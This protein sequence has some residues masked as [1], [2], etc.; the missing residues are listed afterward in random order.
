MPG[1]LLHC[2][3]VLDDPTVYV[4]DHEGT[5]VS[6]PPQTIAIAGPT[7]LYLL[8]APIFRDADDDAGFYAAALGSSS[9]WPGAVVYKSADQFAWT[10]LL[11]ITSPATVGSATT[12]L[13]DHGPY[14]WDEANTVTIRLV[15]GSLASDSELNVLN[16]ANAG[17][18]ANEVL[19]WR[20]ATL[21]GDGTYTLSGLLRGRKGSEGQTGNHAA[22]DRF[23][24]IDSA[25]WRRLSADSAELNTTRYYKGVTIGGRVEDTPTLPFINTGRGKKPY[26]PVRVEGSRD[27]SD[28]LTISWVRR[29]RL[30]A[31]WL[32]YVEEV[33]LGEASEAYEIDILDGADVVRTLEA[34]GPSVVY[35]VADQTSDFGGPQASVSVRVYQL[36]SV[37]DRG[38]PAEATV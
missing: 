3:A 8:D 26:A 36:S 9:A 7:T 20:T 31:E 14:T 28:N 17:L 13:G 34:S 19:Q 1:G 2:Q 5:D 23:V 38:Y 27:G 21:N 37:V 30:S 32:D 11:A 35:S 12:A 10:S 25:A 6:I 33:P 4:T 15:R 16:G 24:L 22:G 18:L 29:T